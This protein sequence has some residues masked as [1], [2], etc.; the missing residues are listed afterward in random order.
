M[1]NTATITMLVRPTA[2][3]TVLMARL[4]VPS[5]GPLRLRQIS[6]ASIGRNTAVKPRLIARDQPGDRTIQ[7]LNWQKWNRHWAP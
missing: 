5:I 7:P 6:R 4:A 1:A 2:V 3:N